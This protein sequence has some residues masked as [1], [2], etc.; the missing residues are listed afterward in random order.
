MSPEDVVIT[1]IGMRTAVGND[2]IQT[3]SAV[4]AG[5]SRFAGWERGGHWGDGPRVTA[6]QLPEHL[7]NEPWYEK[8]DL[9]APQPI[10]E[11]LWD[12]ALHDLA[13][14]RARSR[15][16]LGVYLATPRADRPGVDPGP[17]AEFV[18]QTEERL[19]VPARVD[20]IEHV[21]NDHA[22]G[23]GALARATRALLERGI[24][25]ALVVGI[26]SL[27]HT[28]HIEAMAADLPVLAYASTAIPDTLAGA[29]LQFAPKDLELAAELLAELAY[30]DVV[31]QRIIA[32]QRRRLDDFGPARLRQHLDHLLAR[33]H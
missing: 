18:E 20:L 21:T 30:N 17:Y 6:A 25:V 26:D 13:A 29:G 10:H 23:L 19:G 32:G 9:I 15:G 27:L 2:A 31:R 33:V 1:G 28:V 22:A 12:A 14:L 4:R 3:A 7:G 8:V 5:I 24:D 11:A 16:T